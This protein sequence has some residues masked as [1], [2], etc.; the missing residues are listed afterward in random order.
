L[1]K[2]VLKLTHNTTKFCLLKNKAIMS[3]K[4]QKKTKSSIEAILLETGFRLPVTEEEIELYEKIF[5]TTDIILPKEMDNP[6]F[7]FDQP[8]ESFNEKKG[9][10]KVISIDTP[11]NDYFKKLVLAAEIVNQL[12]SEYTFGHIKFVKINFICGEVCNMQLSTNYGKYAAGPLD[13]KHMHSVDAEFK[14]RKW[15]NV[16]KRENGYGF[17]Y[18]PG[19][20]VDEYKKYYLGYFQN[21]ASSINHLIELFR[22]KSTDFCEIVATLFFVWKNANDQSLVISNDLLMTHFYA[23]GEK[24]KRFIKEDLIKAIDWMEREQIVPNSTK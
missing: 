9:E 14:R 23:W 20:N 2:C 8:N 12:Y 6:S 16:K 13:P 4:N 18:E 15:F 19:E 3:N 7:L 22:K 10:T 24:K 21:Q 17:K 5:G 1:R 11:K